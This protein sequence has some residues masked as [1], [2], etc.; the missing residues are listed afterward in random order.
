MILYMMMY[1]PLSCGL[2]WLDYDMTASLL[3]VFSPTDISCNET[4]G[5]EWWSRGHVIN[6]RAL[7]MAGRV[8]FPSICFDSGEYWRGIHSMLER[9][10]M[11]C[12]DL[13]C[14]LNLNVR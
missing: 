6:C 14:A 5:T 3:Q 9:R 13:P 10:Q 4:G 1:V 8:T 11:R 12:F 2:A 7:A